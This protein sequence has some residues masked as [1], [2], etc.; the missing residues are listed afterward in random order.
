MTEMPECKQGKNRREKKYSEVTRHLDVKTRFR[1]RTIFEIV[2]EGINRL[3]LRR[4]IRRLFGFEEGRISMVVSELADPSE[5]GMAVAEAEMAGVARASLDLGYCFGAYNVWPEVCKSKTEKYRNDNLFLI[6]GPVHNYLCN[7]LI[8][9]RTEGT[10]FSKDG[11]I[12][13]YQGKDY[14]CRFRNDGTPEEDYGIIIKMPNPFNPER[15]IIICAGCRAFGTLAAT[16]ALCNP[17][18]LPKISQLYGE[19]QPFEILVRGLW[20]EENP[21]PTS[22]VCELNYSLRQLWILRV[23]QLLSWI[24]FIFAFGFAILLFKSTGM[25]VVCAISAL[26]AWGIDYSLAGVEEV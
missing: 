1:P 14:T 8:G 16:M 2:W 26:G 18:V 25:A 17:V 5:P 11:N 3:F 24:G 22:F 6:G 21:Y 12:L 19:G 9:N 7:D 15:W 20:L 13:H 4:R 23:R 10:R